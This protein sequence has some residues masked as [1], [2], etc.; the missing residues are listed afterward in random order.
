[1]LNSFMRKFSNTAKSPSES[2]L[3]VA[4]GSS[5]KGFVVKII[6]HIA[7]FANCTNYAVA[8]EQHGAHV[9]GVASLSIA[10]EDNVLEV[11]FESPG[12]NL[13]GFEHQAKTDKE[14]EIIS[15]VSA[16]LS[17]PTELFTFSG[18]ECLPV[19]TEVELTGAVGESEHNHAAK[20]SDKHSQVHAS[21]RFECSSEQHSGGIPKEIKVALF[22]RFDGLGKIN[23]QWVTSDSQ[24]SA[25]LDASKTII[26][27]H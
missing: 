16:Q 4:G 2:R 24:G 14:L 9:H 15:S 20:D 6:I 5:P 13:L 25:I 23:A 10:V 19:S 8:R 3:S 26:E 11:L 7:F 1:M 12:V 27:L 22:E 17:E 18:A 21:Y